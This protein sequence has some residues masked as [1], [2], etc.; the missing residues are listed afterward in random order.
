MAALAETQTLGAD[1]RAAVLAIDAAVLDV[2]ASTN[3]TTEI[4]ESVLQTMSYCLED[5]LD[6]GGDNATSAAVVDLRD[7]LFNQTSEQLAVGETAT[8]SSSAI[9]LSVGLVDA[10]VAS[11][12]VAL[13]GAYGV[14]IPGAALPSSA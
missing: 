13:A 11:A 14:V 10:G 12:S 6:E 9:V 2:T 4:A 5:A 3:L 7:E 1:A 8:T